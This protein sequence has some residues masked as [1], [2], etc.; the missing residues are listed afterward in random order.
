MNSRKFWVSYMND[1]ARWAVTIGM[2]LTLVTTSVSSADAAAPLKLTVA[3]VRD[4]A[5]QFNRNYLSAREEVDKARGDVVKARAGALPII[6]ARGSYTRNFSLSSFFFEDE[7]GNTTELQ[8]GFKNN[9]GASISLQQP[10]YS[11]GKVFTALAI[12]RMY[13]EY[14][15]SGVQLAAAEV[16]YSAEVLFYDAI[17]K[18]ARLDVLQ[19]ALQANSYNLEIVEKKFS[20]GMVSEFEVLRAR[21]EKNNLL[22][23]II[24][25]ESEV[26]LSRKRLKSFLG[27]DFDQPIELMETVDDTGFVSSLE[28]SKLVDTAFSS[29]PEVI[30]AE[31]L[32]G[33]TEKAIKVAKAE[34]WPSLAAVSA[35]DWQSQSDEFTLNENVSKSFTAGLVL[36]VPIFLGG[37]RSGEVSLRRAEH[38]Q[39]KLAEKQLRDD[40]R[41]EVEDAYRGLLQAKQ[42]LDIQQTNIAE[43]EEG[44]K[45][46]NLRYDSGVGTLLEVL[47][48]QVALTNARTSQ[49]EA[50]FAFREA[51]ARLK[52]VTTIQHY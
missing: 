23:G 52:K 16:T 40:I 29:R 9:F 4:R 31:Y 5:L 42:A 14:T 2:A 34:Y 8:F 44:L 7:E 19:K 41:L 37:A 13:R 48:A 50:L 49:A 45:I 47:S 38:S 21:V 10:I 46:A 11:G 3:D 26:E 25:A 6:T 22:P 18:R 1:T 51:R 30:Q 12:A 39:A 17:L 36:S 32:S 20:Q 24:R 28:L 35:F 27:V 15:E 33:I 43:A